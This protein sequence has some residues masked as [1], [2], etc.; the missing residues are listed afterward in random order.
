ME[1]DFYVYILANKKN[2]TLYKGMTSNLLHRIGQHKSGEG[3]AFSIKHDTKILV[4]Y[5]HCE[6]WENAVSWEKRLRRYPRQ[7][8]INLIEA[9]NPEWLDLWDE[10]NGSHARGRV[11]TTSSLSSL[12]G[13]S[14]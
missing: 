12:H 1:K 3:S 5:K 14:V 6:N 9:D 13:L 10:I 11:M 4:W 8:K 7:W 2:G